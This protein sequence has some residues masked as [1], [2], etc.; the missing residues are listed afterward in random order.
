DQ[1]P[2]LRFAG[3][4]TGVGRA[5]ALAP[6]RLAV[7]RLAVPRLAASGTSV[8]PNAST[9]SHSSSVTGTTEIRERRK[10]AIGASAGVALIW[11]RATGRTIGST[12]STST[13]DQSPSP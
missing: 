3:R 9:I 12:A 2:E 4:P 11:A 10:S 5:H 1:I 8:A 6:L 13:A 7:P